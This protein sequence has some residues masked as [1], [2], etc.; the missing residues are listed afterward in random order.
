MGKGAKKR[1]TSFSSVT[2]ASVWISPQIFLIFVF[3][4]F[5]HTG[6]EFQVSPKLP[7]LKQTHP[8]K[9][10]VFLVKYL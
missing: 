9:K 2:S 8:S 6:I 10:A 3:N 5:A 4:P 1:P 7:N